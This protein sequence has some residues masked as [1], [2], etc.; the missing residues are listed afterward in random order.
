MW[1]KLSKRLQALLTSIVL[2]TILTEKTK[3]KVVTHLNKK[4]DIP[5][6]DEADEQELIEL[7]WETAELAINEALGVESSEEGEE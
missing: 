6:L 3:E 5:L 1:D 4:L 2:K 7:M